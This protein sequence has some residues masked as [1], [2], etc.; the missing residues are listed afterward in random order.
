MVEHTK[1]TPAPLAFINSMFR[2]GST[3]IYHAFKQSG[4]LKVFHEP[5]H[6][7]LASILDGSVVVNEE[8]IRQMRGKLRHD[9]L[10]SSYFDEFLPVM[11]EMKGAFAASFAYQDFF[12]RA[13]TSKPKLKGYIDL[14]AGAYDTPVILQCT[15]TWGRLNWLAENYPNAMHIALIR[16]PWSQWYSYKVDRYIDSSTRVI[17]S[18][19]NL[20]M[21][22]AAVCQTYDWAAPNVSPSELF[23]YFLSHPISPDTNYGL[24]FCTWAYAYKELV[25]SSR[26][27]LDMDALSKDKACINDAEKRLSALGIDG[28]DLGNL[29]LLR[30]GLDRSE[31]DRFERIEDSVISH[32][33]PQDQKILSDYLDSS[34]RQEVGMKVSSADRKRQK[35]LR[36]DL[37]TLERT[38]ANMASEGIPSK[39]RG[40]LAI[41]LQKVEGLLE[42][43]EEGIKGRLAGV[44]AGIHDRLQ[45][46]D[47]GLK[48]RFSSLDD[49][50]EGRIARLE[51]TIQNAE[52]QLSDAMRFPSAEIAES[53]S[54]LGRQFRDSSDRNNDAFARLETLYG[55]SEGSAAEI[56][57]LKAEISSRTTEIA[58]LKGEISSRT[59]EIANLNGEI[60]SRKTEIADLKSIVADSAAEIVSLKN[61][62]SDRTTEIAILKAEM[63]A[64]IAELDRLTS[65]IDGVMED[66]KHR[67]SALGR[68]S[69]E[70]IALQQKLEA[71]A[72]L[73]G[74]YELKLEEA[75]KQAREF[76]RTRKALDTIV[77]SKSWKLTSPLRSMATF[78]RRRYRVDI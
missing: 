73:H 53:I 44:D 36:A 34:R 59:I 75:N 49:A 28:I 48:H 69:L 3:F 64:R 8:S 19:P 60:T 15:R 2:S 18:A 40:E 41:D 20:P 31:L 7:V 68:Q 67:E 17:L 58:N 4:Q 12:S 27:V 37:N 61:E 52:L 13:G 57:N 55:S 71:R 66:A 42:A 10:E 45:S 51:A 46:V 16:N 1:G 78:L 72:K 11:E 74:H 23:A 32:F 24:F 6:E 50:L 54:S 25:A 33:A 30:Q 35:A 76:A 47:L 22:L 43:I 29:H 14:L 70:L 65:L 39:T 21:E 63:Q 5:F 38:H 9:F 77:N 26:L 56:A 62:A